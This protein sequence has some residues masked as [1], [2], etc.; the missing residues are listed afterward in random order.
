VVLT[1]L[2]R[3]E[4]A[5][6]PEEE[7]PQRGMTSESFS[8]PEARFL[9]VPNYNK[10][11]ERGGFQKVRRTDDAVRLVLVEMKKVWL[12]LCKCPNMEI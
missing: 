10:K 3:H 11:S 6:F 1:V 8:R 12:R 9:R 5:V 7:D 4:L 2:P